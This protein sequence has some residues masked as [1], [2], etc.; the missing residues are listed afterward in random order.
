[1]AVALPANF[2]AEMEQLKIVVSQLQAQNEE[3]RT[4]SKRQ[5]VGAHPNRGHRLREDF[6]PMCDEDVVQWMPEHE[7]GEVVPGHGPCS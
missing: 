2:V 5:A 6:E 4:S 3:L 1:M 7:L